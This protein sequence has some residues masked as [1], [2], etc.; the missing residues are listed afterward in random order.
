MKITKDLTELDTI[1]GVITVEYVPCD[2]LQDKRAKNFE[3]TNIRSVIKYFDAQLHDI[4]RI[5]YLG[6]R[7]NPIGPVLIWNDGQLVGSGTITVPES[8]A[9]T[10]MIYN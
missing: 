4:K 3:G 8:R 5:Y 10:S 7:S 6:L 2:N 1:P 9:K